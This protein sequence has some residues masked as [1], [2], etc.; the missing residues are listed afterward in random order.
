[1]KKQFK[2]LTLALALLTTTACGSNEAK[3]TQAEETKA[4][5]IQVVETKEKKVANVATPKADAVKIEK[6]D[7]RNYLIPQT[8]ELK[9][10]NKEDKEAQETVEEETTQEVAEENEVEVAVEETQEVAKANEN[11]N[12]DIDAVTE[13]SKSVS[14]PNAVEENVASADVD[15]LEVNTVESDEVAGGLTIASPSAEE[16]KAYW[17]NYESQ[18]TDTKDFLGLNLINPESQE[19]FLSAPNADLNALNL[20]EVSLAA[21]EDA[22]HIANTARF[23]SGITNELSLGSDQAQFAQAATMVNR[24]NLQVSHNPALP[25][26]LASDSVEYVNG[27]YGAE[28]SNLAASFNILDSVVEYLQDDLGNENQLE[29]GHRRWVLNPQASL[30]G[31]GQTDEFNAMFVNNNNY[32]GENAN[33]VYAYP[34]ETAIS[35]FQSEGS[36][37][38]LMFGENFDLTNAQV[39]VTDL[40]T[41]EVNTAANVDDSFKGNVKAITFG[42]G[43]NYEAGT[44]LQ[45]KVSGVTKNGQDYPVE[46]TVNYMSIR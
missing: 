31:F 3:V 4:G 16:V 42:Y 14:L 39:E 12:S 8:V 30:V 46:Y 32:A 24:L 33:T 1:M 27:A 43:M 13:T 21:Q 17:L 19:A 41:G 36:S 34:G 29:V 28:N 23:A 45:V 11:E 2:A 18:A 20:G 6:E 38:S 25:T 7:N 9:E 44:K 5:Q 15:R 10:E 35:E 37:L 26:G 40:A 22:L